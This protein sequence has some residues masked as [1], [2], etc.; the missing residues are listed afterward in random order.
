[1]STSTL[2]Q[3]SRDRRLVQADF[4]WFNLANY[5]DMNSMSLTDWRE[6]LSVR[7][8]ALVRVRF[9]PSEPLGFLGNLDEVEA[10][11]RD[12]VADTKG[13]PSLFQT[14]LAKR[15]ADDD[16]KIVDDLCVID[17]LHNVVADSKFLNDAIQ[18]L[19]AFEQF[20]GGSPLEPLTTIVQP[21]RSFIDSSS[22]P[23][24][25]PVLV[26]MWA[27]DDLIISEFRRWLAEA[28]D[29][30]GGMNRP[31][32]WS[33][34]ARLRWTELNVL[35]YLDLIIF[36]VRIANGWTSQALFG[37]LLFPD[38]INVDLTERV[39]K[40]VHPLAERLMS[41]SF[42]TALGHRISQPE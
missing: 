7:E 22:P 4:T 36:S 23:D 8:D 17:A 33:E 6:A 12:P 13:R 24:V 3:M 16:V 40:S 14:S 35:P 38:E 5:R 9:D 37:A 20:L 39:R 28:R 34:A 29:Q 1:M 30:Y 27:D 21:I 2:L 42:L 19:G 18:E 31:V 26:E 25:L 41:R 11:L 32:I 10:M 15:R